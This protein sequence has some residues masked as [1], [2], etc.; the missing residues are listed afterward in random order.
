ME[1][2]P[3]DHELGEYITACLRH[4]Q[5]LDRYYDLPWWR[6]LVARKPR[7]PPLRGRGRGVFTDDAQAELDRIDLPP[8]SPPVT[9]TQEPQ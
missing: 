4:D 8:V 2:T 9:P 1:S 3:I 7:K 6:R 5:A